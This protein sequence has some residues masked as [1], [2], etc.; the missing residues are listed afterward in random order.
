[1]SVP[2]T[3][4]ASQQR[5]IFALLACPSI[6][7]AA[8]QAKVSEATLHR[9]LRLPAFH[10]AYTAARQQLS[11]HAIGALQRAVHTAVTTLE[12]VMTNP[13]VAAATRAY[14][15]RTTL[16]TALR[17]AEIESIEGRLA[18][19]ELALTQREGRR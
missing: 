2:D 14:A 3:L 19:I 4:S 8:K 13:K 6:V 1:M 7:E 11:R 12:G 17:A 9:W 5:A 15:A 10:E 16:E 18:A